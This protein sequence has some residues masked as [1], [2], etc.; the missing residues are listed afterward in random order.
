MLISE[1]S[2]YFSKIFNNYILIIF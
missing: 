2:V 1:M